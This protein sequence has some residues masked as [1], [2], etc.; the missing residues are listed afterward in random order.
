MAFIEPAFAFTVPFLLLMFFL[1]PQPYKQY[2]AAVLAATNLIFILYS[3][4]LINQLIEMARW[5]QELMRQSGIQA[6]GF[7]AF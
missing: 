2:A 5:G 6:G 4:F 3:I 7:A 1:G